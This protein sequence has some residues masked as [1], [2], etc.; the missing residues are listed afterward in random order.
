MLTELGNVPLGNAF[1]L[2]SILAV[3]M[4]DENERSVRSFRCEKYGLFGLKRLV[5]VLKKI[6]E[7]KTREED[8]LERVSS[9]KWGTL[10]IAPHVKR[11]Y[12]IT[13]GIS[14]RGVIVAMLGERLNIDEEMK[15]N[16]IGYAGDFVGLPM[17]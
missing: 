11:R 4:F 16:D 17:W 10:V 1:E 14:S 5:K 2:D 15:V 9:V 7:F 3:R 6:E 12:V 8:K 13:S